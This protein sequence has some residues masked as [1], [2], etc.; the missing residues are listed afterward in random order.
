MIYAPGSITPNTKSIDFHVPILEEPVPG[1]GTQGNTVLW[2]QSACN[3][4][5]IKLLYN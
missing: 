5:V 1:N 2:F 3:M 4:Q